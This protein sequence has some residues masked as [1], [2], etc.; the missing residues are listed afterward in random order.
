MKQN[1]QLERSVQNQSGIKLRGW[2]QENV[3]T[4]V[5]EY[6]DGLKCDLSQASESI[7]LETYTFA[8]DHLGRSIVEE[9]NKASDRGV[10]VRVMVDGFG[11]SVYDVQF[12]LSTLSPQI[13][14]K[15]YHPV[16]WA[17][18]LLKS[19]SHFLKF[20]LGINRRNHRKTCIVDRTIAW[21]G[22]MNISARH[23][24][25][26][27]TGV[28]VLSRKVQIL[29]TIFSQ[30]WNHAEFETGK[31]S[32]LMG[33]LS[34]PVSLIRLNDSWKMR[35]RLFRDL[36]QRIESAR[37]RIWITN[38]YFI[39]TLRLVRAL[40]KA[41]RRGVDVRI[42]VPR[43]CDVFFI[44]LV[45]AAFYGGLLESGVRI[46]EYL[47]TMLHAKTLL[48]DNWAVLGSSNLNHRSLNLDLEA[49]IVLTH[50]QS[51]QKLEDQFVEDTHNSSEV[52]IEDLKNR[53][54]LQSR[55]GRALLLL[56]NWM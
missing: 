54:W 6:F 30:T 2:E 33:S 24:N 21:V 46:F 52:T 55:S 20:L 42:V 10:K 35:R 22:G 36:I 1:H 48:V 17:L 40:T 5:E 38:A 29:S 51:R 50:S 47:P 23:L 4:S 18:P 37:N 44:P 25:W 31:P 7:D 19:F 9:L 39:P 28:R 27:D 53:T 12:L 8:N 43:T 15:V 16:P 26:R 3:F 32:P 41:A 49:D 11:T 13:K 34:L 14:F 45:R 56:K